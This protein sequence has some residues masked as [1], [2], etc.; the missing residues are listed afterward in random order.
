MYIKIINGKPKSLVYRDITVP[1]LDDK[2]LDRIMAGQYQ[3]HVIWLDK[4]RYA[5]LY[6]GFDLHKIN[7]NRNES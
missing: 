4:R 1:M 3:H 7:W 5:G 6:R 2:Q